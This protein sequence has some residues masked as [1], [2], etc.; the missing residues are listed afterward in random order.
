VSETT[1][2]TEAINSLLGEI[3]ETSA[4]KDAKKADGAT[5]APG[6]TDGLKELADRAAAL[7]ARLTSLK[8]D[9]ALKVA[10]EEGAERKAEIDAAVKAALKNVRTPSLAAAIGQGPAASDFGRF[11]G[12]SMMDPHP[13]MK[14]AFRDYQAGEFILG[15]MNYNGIGLQGIDID[16]IN[17]GKAALADL[18]VRF[19]GVPEDSHAY[20]MIDVVSDGHGGE[21]AKATLGTTGATGGYVLPNNL[22]D[23]VLKPAVQGVVYQN[24]VTVRNGVNVRGIDQPYRLGAPTRMSFTDWGAEKPNINESY[25]SYTAYLGTLAAIYDIS[26]QYARFS[27]GSAEQDVMDELTKAAILGENYYIS[28]GG[29]GTG[30]VGGAAGVGDPTYGVYTALAAASAFLSYSTAF[31][32]ASTSTL[33]GSVANALV[34]LQRSLAGRNRTPTAYVMDHTTYFTAIGEGSDTAGFWNSPEGP[35]R[36]GALPGY[37]RTPSGGLSYWGIPCYYDTNLGTNATTKIVIGAEWNVFKLYRGMEF[38]IDTSDQAGSR[39]SQNLVGFRGEEEIGFNAA[40]GV[41]VGAAQLYT[42]VIP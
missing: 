23:T 21:T 37:G 12:R 22:V 24:L 19:G 3:K 31:S 6:E 25:G 33:A 9:E 13:A 38:R 7:D 11:I 35:V 39:W 42:S 29:S 36:A 8:Q 20:S 32:S 27:A 17:A 4:R 1:E 26:K 40:T 30:G 28:V 34:Q 15:V 2:L 14:A 18:G 5:S 16:V 41:N 10:R